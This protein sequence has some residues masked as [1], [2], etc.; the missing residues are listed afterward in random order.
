MA[1]FKV[2][3]RH[4]KPDTAAEE[5]VLASDTEETVVG[6]RPNLVASFPPHIQLGLGD[7]A[8]VAVET[9]NL[10]FFDEATGS[11]LR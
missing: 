10:H 9:K 1:Y 4:V 3:A 8:P 11:P 7:V 5:E 2:D 6:T